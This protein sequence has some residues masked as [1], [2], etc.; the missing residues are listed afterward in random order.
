MTAIPETSDNSVRIRAATRADLLAVYRL[1]KACFSAPWPYQAFDA[2]LDGE[3]FLVATID[4][5]L[6]GY[7][8]ADVLP[9]FGGRVG[10]VKDLA[11]DERYRRQGVASRM[12]G[13][14]LGE[15]ALAGAIRVS[16]EVRVDNDAAIALYRAF[17][18]SADRREAGYYAD[19][20]DALVMTRELP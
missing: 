9:R 1:E 15:L 7:V 16:L 4:G 14:A 13:S 12:L 18:F 3:A 11:V 19:G 17:G 2:H 5:D 8:V 10:H 20:E 6:A